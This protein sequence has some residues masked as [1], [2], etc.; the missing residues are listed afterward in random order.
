[1]RF[2]WSVQLI[3]TLFMH[4][5]KTFPSISRSEIHLYFPKTWC[6]H[7]LP[8]ISRTAEQVQLSLQNSVKCVD[9]ISWVRL[10]SFVRRCWVSTSRIRTFTSCYS[11]ETCRSDVWWHRDDI[12]PS[13]LKT[14]RRQISALWAL[15]HC[16]HTTVVESFLKVGTLHHT[17]GDSGTN[18]VSYT[19]EYAC[20]GFHR[21]RVSKTQWPKLQGPTWSQFN[22][23]HDNSSSLILSSHWGSL[24]TSSNIWN[25]ML[26]TCR[27]Q[28]QTSF[29]LKMSN[30]L[31]FFG[32]CSY[33]SYFSGWRTGLKTVDSVSGH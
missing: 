2:C 12:C 3:L 21:T 13:W 29:C 11:R 10:W 25:Q 9:V 18:N 26:I 32:C 27:T 33:S 19:S 20:A 30:L 16:Y 6:K 14:R 22:L 8:S 15:C 31:W 24:K 23:H 4:N 5:T 28:K 1:M 7:K 17:A